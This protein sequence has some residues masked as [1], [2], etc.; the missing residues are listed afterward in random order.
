VLAPE[1]NMHVCDATAAQREDLELP[2]VF[3]GVRAALSTLGVKLETPGAVFQLI[4]PV[5]FV[6]MT[7]RMF[8]QGLYELMRAGRGDVHDDPAAHGITGAAA[9]LDGDVRAS[10]GP[11]TP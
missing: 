6:F 10:D 4:A 2:G 11:K 7:V 1:G 3:C 8:G 9:E 5:M